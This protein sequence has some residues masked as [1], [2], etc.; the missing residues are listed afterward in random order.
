MS[1]NF[2]EAIPEN[3]KEYD[4]AFVIGTVGNFIVESIS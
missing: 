1:N 3:L 4:Q 2:D